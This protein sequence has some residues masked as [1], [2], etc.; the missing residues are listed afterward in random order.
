[1]TLRLLTGLIAGVVALAACGWQGGQGQRP[2][3]RGTARIALVNVFSGPP[4]Y[5]G[6]YVQN[7]L[8]VQVDALNAQGGL[9]GFK[10]EV[11]AADDEQNPAKAAELIREQLAEGDVKLLV[12]PSTSAAALAA[13]QVITSGRVPNCALDLADEALSNAPYTFRIQQQDQSRVAALLGYVLRSRSDIKRLGFLNDGSPSGQVYDRQLQQQSPRFGLEY[14]G[15]AS[16]AG[17]SRAAVGQ[18]MQRGAQALVLPAETGA[19]GRSVQAV[20]QVAPAKLLLLGTSALGAYSFAQ[21]TGPAV[22]GL[23]FENTIQSYLTDVPQSRWPPLYRSFV[24]RITGQYGYGAN[25]VEMKGLP[26]AADC[27]VEWS[28]AVRA[29]NTFD[30]P[31]VVRAWE[32][33]DLG[34]ADTVLGARE[35]LSRQDHDGLGP[36]GIFVYQWVSNGDRWSLRQLIGPSL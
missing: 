17:D 26:P 25:G 23:V 6:E 13:R 2:A 28:R 31:A 16:A 7:S 10:L 8:Q 19:A 12:G 24:S 20:D 33:L 15:N 11:V 30:G 4:G 22:N 5:S 35:K 34:P 36:E 27:I 29:A 1:V 32:S 3:Q 21:Q 9:L 14:V 18:L